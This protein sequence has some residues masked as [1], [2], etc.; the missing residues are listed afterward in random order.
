MVIQKPKDRLRDTTKPVEIS[1][2]KLTGDALS[3]EFFHVRISTKTT[4][5]LRFGYTF[6]TAG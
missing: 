2:P 6:I 3:L 4:E 1:N 5:R